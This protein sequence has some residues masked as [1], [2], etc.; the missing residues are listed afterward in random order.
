ML[1]CH[2]YSANKYLTQINIVRMHNAVQYG[3][4]QPCFTDFMM[5]FEMITN[6]IPDYCSRELEGQKALGKYQTNW[7]EREQ[8][9]WTYMSTRV[10]CELY[11]LRFGAWSSRRHLSVDHAGICCVVSMF[12][13]HNTASLYLN[14]HQEQYCAVMHC[15]LWCYEMWGSWLVKRASSSVAYNTW[16][17]S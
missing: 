15:T 4:I 8:K 3:T 12:C 2:P 13:L 11:V 5:R 6:Q 14:R 9:E 17:R 1:L 7:A 16:M 10:Q